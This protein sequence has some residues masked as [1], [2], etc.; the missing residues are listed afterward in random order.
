[1]LCAL[2]L[3]SALFSFHIT[4][5][6]LLTL[7]APPLLLL[8]A[9]RAWYAAIAA[10]PRV[11]RALR[12][13]GHPV[14]GGGLLIANYVG[15]H[16][17]ANF[18]FMM[19]HPAVHAFALG[20]FI[21]T[22]FLAWWPVCCPLPAAG[23]IRE[24][25]QMVHL[26]LLGAPLQVLAAVISIAKTVLYPWYGDAPRAFGLTPLADQQLGGLILWV[27]GGLGLWIAITAVW[28]AWARRSGQRG[29]SRPGEGPGDE[30]PLTLPKIR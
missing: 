2:V 20:L 25:A 19:R 28:L 1:M 6:L 7:V 22:A 9:P 13:A 30:P 29:L 8:G 21:V 26:F 4:Q 11:A 5:V 27:P 3:G 16:L 14:L 18:D 17:P 23:R 24:P 12:I 10:R 15:W